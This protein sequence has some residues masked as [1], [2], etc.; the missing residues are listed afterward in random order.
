MQKNKIWTIATVVALIAIAV[1]GYL[2]I[3][4]K[5]AYATTKENEYD[6]AFYEVVEYVQNVKT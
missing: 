5:N 3:N 1:L 6:M 4:Q 2:F